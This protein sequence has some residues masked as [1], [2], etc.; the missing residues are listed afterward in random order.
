[1]TS[2]CPPPYALPPSLPPFPQHHIRLLIPSEPHQIPPALGV[3]LTSSEYSTLRL[4]F[5]QRV[6]LTYPLRPAL[7]D[8]L[9]Q[10][11]SDLYAWSGDEALWAWLRGVHAEHSEYPSLPTP[12]LPPS[13]QCSG[14]AEVDSRREGDQRNVG[15]AYRL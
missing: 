5:E 10:L 9:T 3:L 12:L 7:L 1:M 11:E 4:H 2:L 6:A 14:R 13:T 15:S 8:E